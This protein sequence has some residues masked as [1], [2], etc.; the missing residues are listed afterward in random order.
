MSIQISTKTFRNGLKKWYYLEWGKGPDERKAAGIFTY[1]EPKDQIQKNHNKEALA[2]LE[3]KKSHLTIEQQST[4][5]A[6]IPAHR[7]KNN[8]LTIMRTL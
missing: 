5:T 1:A 4:G 3:T 2:L 6:F 8:F 7:F